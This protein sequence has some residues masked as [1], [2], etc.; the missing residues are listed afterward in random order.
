MLILLRVEILWLRA[1]K[2]YY[3][4]VYR[5]YGCKFWLLDYYM[6]T[7]CDYEYK[8]ITTGLCIA[9]AGVHFDHLITTGLHIVTTGTIILLRVCVSRLRVDILI[10]WFSWLLRVYIFWLRVYGYNNITMGLSIATTG[11][12]FDH[13]IT[14]GLHIVNT[15]TSAVKIQT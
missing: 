6:F 15:N 10:T 7:Y 13:F 14:T 4:F 8:N 1:Q 9:T 5:D 3:R 11:V 12:Y 2:Y